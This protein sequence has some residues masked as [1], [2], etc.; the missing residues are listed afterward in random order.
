M[1]RNNDKESGDGLLFH[2]AQKISGLSTTDIIGAMEISNGTLYR[3][4]KKETF[5]TDE[6]AAAAKALGKSVDEIFGAGE[7]KASD[8]KPEKPPRRVPVIGD[9]LAGTDM[10]LNVIDEPVLDEYIDVGDLL[11]DSEA[12]FVVYGNSMTPAYPPGCVIGIKRNLDR[13]IQPGETYLLV[14]KSNRVFKRL[15]YN[16]DE[17]GYVCVSDNTMKYETGPM[18]GKYMY[19]V[20]NIKGEDVIS[21]FDITGMIKRNRNSGIMQRQ[22]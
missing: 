3:L 19:P 4:F 2:N 13:F 5:T 20:F 17:T 14:T 11:K 15:Y 21:V 10:E 18:T 6:K 1:N 9:G 7:Q 22:K 12:A 16:D 8:Q